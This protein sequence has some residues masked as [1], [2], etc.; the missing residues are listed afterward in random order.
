M[1]EQI[2]G[3]CE[4]N[5]D[6]IERYRIGL[7]DEVYVTGMFVSHLGEKKNLPIVRIGTIAAMPEEP[8]KTKYGTHDA[9]L[10]EVRSIDGLSG[11]PVCVNLEHRRIPYTMPAPPLPHPGEIRHLTFFVGMVLGYNLVHNPLDQIEI[12]R[13]RQGKDIKE[14]AIVPMNTG[15]AVVLPVWQIIEAIDQLAIK[16]ARAKLLEPTSFVPTSAAPIGQG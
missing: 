8:L 9:F 6:R 7:G 10:I 5:A 15:I 1:D 11:S 14:D 16:E 2:V 13:T 3:G 4:L 12:V